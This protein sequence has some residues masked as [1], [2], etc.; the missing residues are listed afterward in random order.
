MRIYIRIYSSTSGSPR[1]PA[2]SFK[3]RVVTQAVGML[4]IRRLKPSAVNTRFPH[5]ATCASWLRHVRLILALSPY[6]GDAVSL[7][8]TDT[9]GRALVMLTQDC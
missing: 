8:Y 7:V 3:G 4:L 1:V 2:E 6:A 9:R 5:G